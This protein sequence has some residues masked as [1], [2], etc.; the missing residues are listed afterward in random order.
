MYSF[1]QT[2]KTQIKLKMAEDLQVDDILND[3]DLYLAATARRNPYI[4]KPLVLR[5]EFKT[6]PAVSDAQKNLYEIDMSQLI[7]F[8]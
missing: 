7:S 5:A 3:L 6:L 8:R 4:S 1:Q 2:A